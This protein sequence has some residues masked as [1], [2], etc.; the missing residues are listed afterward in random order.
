M[1]DKFIRPFSYDVGSLSS[2][3]WLHEV[4]TARRHYGFRM[5]D[6]IVAGVEVVWL[7]GTSVVTCDPYEAL[8]AARARVSL[9]AH[10]PAE[11]LENLR[12]I[13]G[14]GI[15]EVT[16]TTFDSRPA[17]T[18]LLDPSRHRCGSHE[19]F[20]FLNGL[21]LR[22]MATALRLEAPSQLIIADVDGALVGVQVWTRNQADL[23]AWEAESTP[24]VE[25]I[26]FP[27]PSDAAP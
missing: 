23:E 13:A 4:V 25:S 19:P 9:G 20:V 21:G 1:A 8:N 17:V 24:F 5:F 2:D 6:Q 26:H 10:S 27:S 12:A 7:A 16:P 11:V 18:A 14:F 22:S 15:G 3:G